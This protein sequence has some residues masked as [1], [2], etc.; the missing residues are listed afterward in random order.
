MDNATWLQQKAESIVRRGTAV[1]EEIARTVV[2]G[3][4]G[5]GAIADG[6]VDVARNVISG[7]ARGASTS[8]SSDEA[9]TLR[10]VIDGLGD[11]LATTAQAAQLTMQEAGG[12][13]TSF[14]REDLERL[15]GG[16]RS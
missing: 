9:H 15:A 7:A 10:A 5:M 1:R 6:L 8:A 13:A 12:R 3:A 14:A 2:E 16:L 4:A 11:G